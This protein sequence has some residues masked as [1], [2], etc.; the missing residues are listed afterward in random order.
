[1]TQP[2]APRLLVIHTELGIT[3]GPNAAA[4]DTENED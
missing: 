1:M 4:D 3:P 2:E